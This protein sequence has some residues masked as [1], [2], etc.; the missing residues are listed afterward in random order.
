MVIKKTTKQTSRIMEMNLSK[1]LSSKSLLSINGLMYSYK[2]TAECTLLYLIILT[3]CP[4]NQQ[5][6]SECL[7]QFADV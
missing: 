7:D 4:V 1:E 6:D 3:K 5:A 2:L